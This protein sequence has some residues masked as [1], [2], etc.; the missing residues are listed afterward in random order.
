MCPM[1]MTTAYLIAAG[2][3]SAGGL[4]A[5]AAAKLLPAVTPANAEARI[6]GETDGTPAHR[7][8]R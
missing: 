8:P 7:L 6:D 1:C 3:A 2:T 5:F 4:V